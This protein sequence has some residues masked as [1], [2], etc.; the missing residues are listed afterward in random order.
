MA[1]PIAMFNL[2][3]QSTPGHYG[4]SQTALFL[5]DFH[6]MFI[7]RADGTNAPISLKV[8]AGMRN[9]ANSLGIQ[10]IHCLIDLNQTPYPTCKN[11]GN[12]SS[13]IT[14]MRTSGGEEPR[15]LVDGVGNDVTFTRRP[16]F[17]SAL[18]SPGLDDFLKEK[19][20]KSLLL[21][22][23]ST[24]GCVLRTA[25]MAGEAEYVVTVISDGCAD[26]EESIHDFV[27]G[28]L[29]NRGYVATASEFREG[30]ERAY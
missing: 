2:K 8:A 30:F 3:D 16:G 5:L 7:H 22:G 9:W 12:F 23:L 1:S 20:I 15:E 4:P 27:V 26:R 28:K 17:I 18:S 21:A 25:V 24:S 29:L 19:D 14:A 10:V 11:A 6:S 13:A